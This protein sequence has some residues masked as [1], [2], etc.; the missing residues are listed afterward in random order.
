MINILKYKATHGY[1]NDWVQML[2]N[3]NT[4]FIIAIWN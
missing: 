2:I 4:I 3:E 1:T